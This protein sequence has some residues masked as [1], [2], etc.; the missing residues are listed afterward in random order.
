M[1]IDG[2]FGIKSNYSSVIFVQLTSRNT[3]ERL[4]AQFIFV[5]GIIIMILGTYVNLNVQDT[6]S[7]NIVVPPINEP[8]L[9]NIP[10]IDVNKKPEIV[11]VK[12]PAEKVAVGKFSNKSVVS[13]IFFSLF[14]Q[15]QKCKF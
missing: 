10:T 11:N 7:K 15:M 13:K 8:I 4:A 12:P 2:L 14:V 9:P 1:M 3:T 5:L 6:N